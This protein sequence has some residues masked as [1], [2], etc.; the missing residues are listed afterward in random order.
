MSY[1]E[2]RLA[3]K[4]SDRQK[5]K[6]QT[7]KV[8]RSNQPKRAPTSKSGDKIAT[9]LP[10]PKLLEKA[11]RVF[12]AWIRER[13]KDKC[14]ISC[15]GPV[16]Q[17]GHY[18]SAGHHSALRFNEVNVNGQCVRC[19]YFEHGNLIHYRAGLVKKYGEQ[20]VL[21]LESSARGGNTKKW[22]RV[23]LMAVADQYR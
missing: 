23:E 21:M 15:G 19:N 9:F 16:E 4:N 13:D 7:V 20:K 3:L 10:L 11:Q 5:T 8:K 14:C 17:A 12:N 1:I 6:N 22:S 2:Q 18:F